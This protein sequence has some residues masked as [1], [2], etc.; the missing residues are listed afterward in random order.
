MV[1][2]VSR[3]IVTG[4]RAVND[5]G[6]LQL[7]LGD[8]GGI[9][10]LSLRLTATNGAGGSASYGIRSQIK[11]IRV[12]T[13][14]GV[15]PVRLSAS[16]LYALNT[17]RDGIAEELSEGVGAGA[18]QSVRLPIYF[19]LA[20]D[21]VDYGLDLEKSVGATLEIDYALTVS[22][23]D[24]F[25]SKSM[26]VDVDAIATKGLVRP[27]YRGIMNTSGAESHKTA[28]QDPHRV[29]IKGAGQMVGL[30]AYAYKS[31]TA[32]NALV[33]NIKLLREG[34]NGPLVDS[35]FGDLQY[36]S[37]TK[38][39]SIVTSYATIWKARGRDG[40]ETLKPEVAPRLEVHLRELVADGDVRIIEEWI[41]GI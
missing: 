29:F 14:T 31:G 11:E 33:S 9:A 36:Q 17:L 32:D 20:R 24:G 30:Y 38:A 25:V 21:D 40:R 18:T 22:G 34:D 15:Y 1:E 10:A 7:D 13:G 28:V 41:G 26:A 8:K 3:N 12:K 27:V 37:R 23:T 39:G 35:S 16:D 6:T 4:E 19:G 5:S 2:H